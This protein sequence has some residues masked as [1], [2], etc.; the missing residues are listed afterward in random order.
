MIQDHLG[1]DVLLAELRAALTGRSGEL[2]A[3][4]PYR[5][6]VAQ[7]R[8]G[9]SRQQHERFFADCSRRDRADRAVRA[10]QRPRD[11]SATASATV[12]LPEP[13]AAELR[14]WHGRSG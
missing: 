5:N 2:A 10:G 8:G 3:A 9:V 6:F 4:L 7:S 12:G 14:A 13:V 11:G 1:M